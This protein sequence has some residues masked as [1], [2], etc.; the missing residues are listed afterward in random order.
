MDNYAYVVERPTHANSRYSPLKKKITCGIKSTTSSNQSLMPADS[1]SQANP[2]L[3]P[4]I[5]KEE[6]A[7]ARIVRR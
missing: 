2:V 3:R 5:S 6:L 1:I 4:K 7:Q